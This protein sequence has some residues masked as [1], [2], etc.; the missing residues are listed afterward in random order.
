MI[1]VAKLAVERVQWN[2]VEN[3]ARPWNRAAYRGRIALARGRGHLVARPGIFLNQHRQGI[4]DAIG[5]GVGIERANL[6]RSQTRQQRQKHYKH[7]T[8]PPHYRHD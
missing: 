4:A 8:H 3:I 2:K 5:L 1:I 6:G 7:R